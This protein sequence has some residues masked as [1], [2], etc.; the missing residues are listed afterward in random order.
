MAVSIWG[1][2]E[3]IG[4]GVNCAVVPVALKVGPY[5]LGDWVPRL[6]LELDM[7]VEISLVLMTWGSGWTGTN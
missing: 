5:V 2:G 3:N 7:P 4:E 1:E 6:S